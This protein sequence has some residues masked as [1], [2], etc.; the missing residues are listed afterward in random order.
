[1]SLKKSLNKY[2]DHTML[3]PY[4]T[5]KDLEN[6]LEEAVKYKFASICIGPH[7]A[8]LLANIKRKSSGLFSFDICTVVAFPFGN[9]SSTAKYREVEEHVR[10]G[11]NEI[12]FVLNISE[13]K[14]KNMRYILAELRNISDLCKEYG[15]VSKCI[16]ETCYLTKEEKVSIFHW[17]KDFV[18]H[19]DFIKTS[20]GFGSAGAQLEDVVL[21]NE[22]R[23]DAPRPLIK[24]AGGIT[25]LKTALAFINAGADR[26]GMSAGVEVMEE[27]YAHQK[28][29]TE[30]ETQT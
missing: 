11:V 25:D 20:T 4:S 6:L 29:L 18:P 14:N 21:W 27:Y 7:T 23:G 17:I 28:T 19:L 24:A 9:I 30:G 3:K 16:V 26:L 13:L 1:M 8:P 22:L 2:I 12:D 10:A 5:V 15:A